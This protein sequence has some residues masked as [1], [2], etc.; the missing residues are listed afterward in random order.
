MQ[1]LKRANIS[2]ISSVILQFSTGDEKEH[3]I[4]LEIADFLQIC[5]LSSDVDRM[6]KNSRSFCLFFSLKKNDNSIQTNKHYCNLYLNTEKII[7]VPGRYAIYGVA[8]G[9]LD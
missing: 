2:T 3:Q 9:M 8:K 4:N 5:A 6:V 7:L 1:T